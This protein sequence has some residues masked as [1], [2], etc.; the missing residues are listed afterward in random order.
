MKGLR[1][2][3]RYVTREFLLSQ[4]TAVGILVAVVTVVDVWERV[5][6]YLDHQATWREVARF[7]LYSLPFTLMIAIPVSLL[8]GA[9]FSLGR[10]ARR[11][12]LTALRTTG[13]FRGIWPW[14]VTSQGD[15]A[16][17]LPGTRA[18]DLRDQIGRKSRHRPCCSAD[19]Y[20][21][22]SRSCAS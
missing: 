2:I 9:V 16:R 8:L 14:A 21:L 15:K 7:H 22:S 13:L 11:N 18:L 5:D 1:L 4:L 10:L 17:S 6:T 12:E 3:D 20:T 19:R